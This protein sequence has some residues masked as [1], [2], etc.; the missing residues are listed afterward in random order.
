[1]NISTPHAA[2]FRNLKELQPMIVIVTN[3]P[4]PLVGATRSP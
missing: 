1:M 3:V 4:A 2:W